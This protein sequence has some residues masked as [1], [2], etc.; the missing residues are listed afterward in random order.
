[1]YLLLI[2]VH[3]IFFFIA[4]LLWSV[5]MQGAFILLLIFFILYFS[6]L[7][8]S[9]NEKRI[10]TGVQ[11]PDINISPKQ[12]IIIPLIL[13]YFGIYVLAFTVTRDLGA[14]FSLHLYILLVIYLVFAGYIFAFDWDTVFFR[15][16]LRFHLVCSYITI[17][18]QLIYFFLFSGDITS[19]HIL[20]SVV[21][22][23]FSYLFF[24]FFRD[25]NINIF[26]SFVLSAIIAIDTA[27]IYFYPELHIFTLFWITAVLGIAFFEYSPKIRLFFEFI[28]P[29]RILLLTT[30][31]AISV[32]LM[33]S[34]FFGYFHFVWFFPIFIVFLYSV[35]I[36]YCNYVSYSLATLLLFFLYTYLFFPLLTTP[37]LLSSLLFI[38]FFPLCLIGNTYFWEEHYVYDFTILHYGSIGFSF[39]GSLYSL[40]FVAWW[41][42]L[43]LVLACSLFL[44][45]A[46][47]LLSYF[48]FQYR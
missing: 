17:F 40:F 2:G 46:L 10:D 20:F 43:S 47:F 35:H 38:F 21:T 6:P 45:A 18:A 14:N 31:L 24:T 1:M 27:I 33:F 29:T 19:I 12:S 16:A 8:F 42:W 4:Y 15:D 5:L 44:L 26:L 39:F 30:L 11:I 13:T 36:R 32:L 22:I 34:P 37:D 48:R 7:F 28:E 25:E 41:V 23:W 3:A 9:Q